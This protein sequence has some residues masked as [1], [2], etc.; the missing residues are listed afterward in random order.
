MKQK[1]E[2]ISIV[3]VVYLYIYTIFIE[4]FVGRINRLSEHL[5]YIIELLGVVGRFLEAM[6]FQMSVIGSAVANDNVTVGNV[7]YQSGLCYYLEKCQ[8][9]PKHCQDL[10]SRTKQH[11]NERYQRY[12]NH[13]TSKDNLELI[14]FLVA[15][16]LFGWPVDRRDTIGI[17]KKRK[18]EVSVFKS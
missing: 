11:I 15:Y 6:I 8:Y 17:D 18:I 12:F 13:F 16:T 4:I 3:R 14:P 7:F 10:L 2:R 9:E 1:G 5:K